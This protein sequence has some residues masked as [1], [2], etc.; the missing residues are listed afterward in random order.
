M[1]LFIIEYF[2]TDDRGATFVS[3]LTPSQLTAI[4]MVLIAAAIF[5]GYHIIVKKKG[6]DFFKPPL[7]AKE[8]IAAVSAPDAESGAPQSPDDQGK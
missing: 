8:E 4:V 2:R 7:P 1:W 6:K 5:I 3:F